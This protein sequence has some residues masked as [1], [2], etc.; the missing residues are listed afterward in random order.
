MSDARPGGEDRRWSRASY[1]YGLLASGLVAYFLLGLPV[2]LTDCF[3]LIVAVQH[4]SFLDVIGKQFHQAGYLRPLLWGQTK[5]VYELSG[6]Q[7]Y[8]VFR[9]LHGVQVAALVLLFI[10]L[11]R[12]RTALDAALVPV[13]VAILLGGH[14]FQGTVREAFP[15]NTFLT[16]LICCVLAANL[17]FARPRGWI[18][19][20]ACALFVFAALTVE[21]GLLVWVVIAGAWLLGA[22][23]V[24]RHGVGALTA[25]L[26]AY[27]ILRFAVLDVGSPGLIERASGYGFRHYDRQELVET[28]GDRRAWFYAHN[29]GTSILSVLFAEPRAGVWTLTRNLTAEEE[30][31]PALLIN[32][33]ASTL[34]TAAIAAYAWR[35]RRVWWN[36]HFERDDQLVLLFAGVL[37]ANAVI[38]YPYTK[39]VIMSPAGAFAA[40]AAFVA[41]RDA[42][43]RASARRGVAGAALVALCVVLACAWTIRA[44]GTLMGLRHQ[45]FNVRSDWA[46]FDEWVVERSLR[47]DADAIRLKDRLQRDALALSPPSTPVGD[48]LNLFDLD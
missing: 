33:I 41:L 3:S 31:R 35:R 32:V 2:Q 44:G 20:A 47:F 39:D 8:W 24:S 34:A 48:W 29:V 14:T 15:I 10:R 22:R 5:I 26:V 1:A 25:L 12:P 13:A 28:F 30:L 23:G 6:G 9:G 19:A 45:A 46:F 37:A 36:R 43:A 7:Y 11:L 4:D 42:V 16:I 27:F 18:D 21:S 17:A 38:S 40:A